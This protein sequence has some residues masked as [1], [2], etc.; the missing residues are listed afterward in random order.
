MS[1]GHKKPENINVRNAVTVGVFQGVAL[2][3]AFHSRLY[4]L[5]RSVLRIFRDTAVRYS[6]I[7][8]IPAI[9]GGCLLEVKDAVATNV[10]IDVIPYLVGFVIAAVVGVGAIKMVNWLVKSEKFKIF[11]YYTF[12]LGL[13]V[14]GISIY[15]LISG[16]RVSF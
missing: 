9:L 8:G 3:P 4:H 11:A 2:L 15:E 5:Q 13:V 12:I 7:L 10:Q 1:K 14:I 6:F 16:Q